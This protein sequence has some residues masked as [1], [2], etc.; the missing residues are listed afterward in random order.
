MNVDNLVIQYLEV[1]YDKAVV[2]EKQQYASAAALRD[3][4][5]TLLLLI[6][7]N[8]IDKGEIEIVIKENGQS[9]HDYRKIDD[10][11]NMYINSFIGYEIDGFEK[12]DG[13][14]KRLHDFKIKLRE[15][16]I[17]LILNEYE[18]NRKN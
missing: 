9:K 12:S 16:K 5:K 11:V 18:I 13:H 15:V 4:E 1:K 2:V 7:D 10:A 3:T 8:L 17:N 6:N 14:Y